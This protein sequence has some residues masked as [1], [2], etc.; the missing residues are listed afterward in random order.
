[1]TFLL[2]LFGILLN[3]GAPY[4]VSIAYYPIETNTNLKFII[5]EGINFSL[6]TTW[7]ET[8]PLTVQFQVNFE[9]LIEFNLEASSQVGFRT[10]VNGL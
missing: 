6:W 1:M 2:T 9:P 8:Q 5:L 4:T 7:V 10:R 3:A